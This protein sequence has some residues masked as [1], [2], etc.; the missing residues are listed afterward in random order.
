MQILYVYFFPKDKN[1]IDILCM[2][3]LYK[4]FIKDVNVLLTN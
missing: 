3:I 2:S 4:Y 1:N